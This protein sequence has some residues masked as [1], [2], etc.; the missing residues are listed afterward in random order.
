MKKRSLMVVSLIAIAVLLAGVQVATAQKAPS[1]AEVT[2]NLVVTAEARHGSN[3]PE[4]QRDD[5][6][7][8]EGHDRDRVTG[9]QPLQG[10]QRRVHKVGQMSGV[11]VARRQRY[12]S[13][14]EVDRVKAQCPARST[15][16]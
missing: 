10:E 6:M 2:A 13:N 14:K 16:V 7:V 12:Q 15:K 5:V 3:I 4:I 11:K 1:A 9:W 8:Y